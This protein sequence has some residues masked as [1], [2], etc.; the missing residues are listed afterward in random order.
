MCVCV[1]YL[2]YMQHVW[3]PQHNAFDELSDLTL[4]SRHAYDDLHLDINGI[5]SSVEQFS[6]FH[7]RAQKIKALRQ[8]ADGIF[9][10]ID[11]DGSGAITFN[12]FASHGDFD[13]C[14]ESMDQAHQLFDQHAQ[15]EEHT[16][17]SFEFKV[18]QSM[19]E[20]CFACR[21]S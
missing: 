18:S 2:T 17:D 12:E 15:N 9:N 10:Q 3:T 8:S 13:N 11:K 19:R 5:I 14:E 21:G 7:A 16:I 20:S 6:D 1:Q 4:G